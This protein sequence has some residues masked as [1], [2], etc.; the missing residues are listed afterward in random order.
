[1]LVLAC[2]WFRIASFPLRI[3][4]ECPFDLVLLELF[5]ETFLFSVYLI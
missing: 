2:M 3:Y 4:V 1:M 5:F